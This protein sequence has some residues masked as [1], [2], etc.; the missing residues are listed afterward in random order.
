MQ[1]EIN[2]KNATIALLSRDPG[3]QVSVLAEYTELEDPEKSR[4]LGGGQ[5]AFES[6]IDSDA[7]NYYIDS[8]GDIRDVSTVSVNLGNVRYAVKGLVWVAYEEAGPLFTYLQQPLSTAVVTFNKQRRLEPQDSMYYELVQQYRHTR[9]C[10]LGPPSVY[11]F[12]LDMSSRLNWGT[13]NFAGLSEAS[14]QASV[15]PGMPRFKLKVFSL[16]Y[17]FLDISSFSGKVLYV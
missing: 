3:I 15:R 2:E 14:L 4:M 12:A 1:G 9:N 8:D 5:L 17:N 13:A 6:V 16:Y 10:A 11:S 7:T